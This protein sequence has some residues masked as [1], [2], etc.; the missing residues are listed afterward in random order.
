MGEGNNLGQLMF[1]A[2]MSGGVIGRK[3]SLSCTN[4]GSLYIICQHNSLEQAN[5]SFS[6]SCVNKGVGASHKLCEHG[7]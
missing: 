7:G 5:R 3:L 1:T 2:I 4:I 6:L